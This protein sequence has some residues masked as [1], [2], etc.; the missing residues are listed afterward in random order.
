MDADGSGQESAQVYNST[1]A[2]YPCLFLD[3]ADNPHIA[4]KEWQD[5]YYLKWGGS[6]WVDADG[7]GQVRLTNEPADDYRPAWSP[8]GT[9][10]TFHS[11]RDGNPDVY[12]MNADGSSQINLTNDPSND[13]SP[14]WSPMRER[15]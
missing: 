8:D 12:V 9:K 2:Q 14:M 6:M 4:W 13:R 15:E 7:S 10:I 1:V 11:Y 3:S 5:V